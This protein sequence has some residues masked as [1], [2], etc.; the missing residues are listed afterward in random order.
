MAII[1]QS[2]KLLLARGKAATDVDG[3][4]EVIIKV[5]GTFT[6][7]KTDGRTIEGGLSFFENVGP[8][9]YITIDL[10]DDDNLLGLG[11]GTILD[12]FNDDGLPAECKGW[13]F[14]GTDPLELHPV[15]SDDPTDVPAG[16]YLHLIGQKADIAQSDTLFVN[17]H[18]GK[19]IR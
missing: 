16:M 9:D 5:P 8:G 15:V 2:V 6:W 18:W 19:R 13:Y 12:S 7:P 1:P 4:A 3:K 17:L 10:R 14:L 11:A